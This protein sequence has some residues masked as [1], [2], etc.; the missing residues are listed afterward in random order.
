MTVVFSS[1]LQWN[2]ANRVAAPGYFA[3]SGSPLIRFLPPNTAA[4]APNERPSATCLRFAFPISNVALRGKLSRVPALRLR[5][6]PFA[7]AYEQFQT[8]RKRIVS[9]RFTID[10]ARPGP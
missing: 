5:Q 3:S 4:S 2:Q 8:N 6:R 9:Q 10:H 1:F 7:D